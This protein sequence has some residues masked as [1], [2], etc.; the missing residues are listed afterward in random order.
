MGG[1]AI[2]LQ[3]PGRAVQ[4][5]NLKAAR[6]RFSKGLGLDCPILESPAISKFTPWQFRPLNLRSYRQK[7]IF[8]VTEHHV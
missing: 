4:L 8:P 6:S 5:S 1:I 3:F 2:E 7:H